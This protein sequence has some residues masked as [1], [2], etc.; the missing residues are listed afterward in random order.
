MCLIKSTN[1]HKTRLSVQT[2]KNKKTFLIDIILHNLTKD[3]RIF[4]RESNSTQRNQALV[5]SS[6]VLTMYRR[7]NTQTTN[8]IIII[9]Q[10]A[11]ASGNSTWVL[12]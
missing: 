3:P 12:L 11:S 2:K 7:I 5:N 6:T 1:L 9:Q 4:S 8:K 10:S